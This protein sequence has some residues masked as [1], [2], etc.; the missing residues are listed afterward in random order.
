MA[1]FTDFQ[2]YR[3]PVA[4]GDLAVLR[5]PAKEPDAPVV[6]AVHGITANALA[7]AA[8]AEAVDGRATLLAPDLRGRAGSREITGPFG[9]DADADDVIAVLDHA[10]VDQATLLGHSMGAFVC[11]AA[12]ARRPDRV[13]ALVAVDGGLGFD[14]PPGADP[15]EVLLA[16]VGPAIQKLSMRFPGTE[17]YLDFHRD[18]PAFA[19]NWSRQLTAY[20][21]RDTR[22][23]D[24]GQVASS[25]VEEAVRADGRQILLDE[26][27][28]TAILRLPCPVAFLYAQRG[29]LNQDQGLYPPELLTRAGLDGHPDRISVSLVEDTNHYTV[30]GPGP[31]AR[32]VCDAL[33]AV[34]Q[35]AR[36]TTRARTSA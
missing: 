17:E 22:L 8:V 29:I 32:A 21:S 5:W 31:G 19:G 2:E 20:L 23:L 12:A 9:I 13:S 25:C 11:A 27:I 3:V 33:A 16:V 14:L 24:D 18:H 35:Q 15:D 6:V 34:S 28:R 26:Q 36:A 30:I 10:G 7:W 4:G 1:D